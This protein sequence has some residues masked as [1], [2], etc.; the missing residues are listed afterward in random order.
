M[1]VALA[2]GA[3]ALLVEV[4]GSAP[5]AP[6][7]A[8]LVG[9]DG[10]VEGSVTGG[11]V[12]SAVVQ[13][14]ERVLAGGPARLLRYGVSDELAGTAGLM[15][16]GVVHV[17]V[18]ALDDAAA[19]ALDAADAA[20]RAGRAAVVATVLDGTCAG[21]VLTVTEAGVTGTLGAST[22]LARA[23]A[24]DGAGLLDREASQVRSYG[25]DGATLGAEVRVH[26]S[27]SATAPTMLLFGAVD[28]SA[29]LAPLARQLGWAVTISDPRAR[30]AAAPRFA[31][32]AEVH[33]GWP[34]EAFAG[35]RLGPRDAVV[36]FSHDPRLDVPALRG[37]LATDAGYVGALG[38][39]RTTAERNERLRAAGVTEAQLARISAPAGLDLGGRTPEEAAISILAEAIAVRNGRPGGPLRRASG[40]IRPRG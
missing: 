4:E 25:A 1:T 16:G 17:F 37:A 39:R 29:A 5:F 8:L 21:A 34:E 28:F 2:G 7:A 31:R 14:A 18:H 23:V 12:E 19:G 26:L 30:F 24:R 3:R 33:V 22:G 13:E 10:A 27:S 20:A 38:S 40:T 6:G 35:R 36:V 9:A 15:C 11:C 32:A